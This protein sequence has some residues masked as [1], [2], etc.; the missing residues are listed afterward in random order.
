MATVTI[1]ITPEA[2]HEGD[3]GWNTV[4]TRE[5][6]VTLDQLVDT[7]LYAAKGA[8]WDVDRVGAVL[9]KGPEFWG[10]T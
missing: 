7:Y 5:N 10:E 1:T 3:F 6:V 8:G 9:D 4:I 2:D